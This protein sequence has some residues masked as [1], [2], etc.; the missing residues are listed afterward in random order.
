MFPEGALTFEYLD[1]LYR[2]SPDGLNISSDYTEAGKLLG[3]YTM[4]PQRWIIGGESK[5][6]ALSLNTAVHEEARGKGLFVRLAEETYSIAA[7]HGIRGIVGVANANSTPGFVKRLG[8]TLVSPLPVVAGVALPVPLHAASNHTVNAAFLNS[9]QFTLLTARLHFNRPGGAAQEW[10]IDKLR[11][12]LSSPKCQYA[13]HAH[14]SGVL[15]T[16]T[17]T[18]PLGARVVI[19]LK[20]FPSNEV[21]QV[22]TAALIRQAAAYHKAWFFIYSGFNNSASLKGIPL[23]RR[24]LPSPLNL[25]YR[26]LDSTL[27]DAISIQF[28]SFEFLDFDAY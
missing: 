9:K 22:D 7:R 24:L 10:S 12:R 25:I 18:G 28:S 17:A 4:V 3:H 8:F 6:M 5:L 11:W 20:F 2:K 23:P 19:A 26:K 21:D 15:V 27:P 1:W 14:K 16:T 13:L